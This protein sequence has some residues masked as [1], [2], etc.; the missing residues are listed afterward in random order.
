MRVVPPVALIDFSATDIYGD[1]FRLSDYRGNAIILSFF[2]D[3]SC[4][5]CLKRVFD[6][7]VHHRKWSQLGVEIVTVF[8]STDEEMLNFSQKSVR[9]YRLVADPDLKIYEQYGVEQ[10]FAGLLKALAFKMPTIISGLKRSARPSKNPNGKIMPA[11]FLIDSS[12]QI[13]EAWYGSN[14]SGHIPMQK[15]HDFVKKTALANRS[16]L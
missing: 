13:V 11:D 9:R 6:L 4:P 12:G 8:S 7:A 10:S 5:F 16:N 15:L 1:S 3:A 14:A 2:R